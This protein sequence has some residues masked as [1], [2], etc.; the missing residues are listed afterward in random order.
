[1]IKTVSELGAKS[2]G[3][4]YSDQ[5]SCDLRNSPDLATCQTCTQR[6]CPVEE[7]IEEYMSPLSSLRVTLLARSIQGR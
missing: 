2:T 1:M 6:I 3:A 7:Y 4:R 5:L